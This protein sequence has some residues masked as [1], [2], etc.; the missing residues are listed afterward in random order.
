ML[1]GEKLFVG[2]SDFSTLE[3]V[4]NARS[5]RRAQ[6]NPNIPAGL[7]QVVLKALAREPEDATSGRATSRKT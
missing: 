1:T 4:R 2:E 5:R 6:F 3:K 7:E